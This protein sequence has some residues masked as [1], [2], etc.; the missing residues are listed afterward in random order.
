MI[1]DRIKHSLIRRKANVFLR[2]EFDSFGSHSQVGRA[3][4]AL[5]RAGVLVRLGKGVYAKAKPS[6]LTGNPIPVMP[7]EVLAPEILKK[8]RVDVVPS[9]QSRE[10]N[11]GVS[12]QVPAGVVVDVGTQRVTRILGFNGKFVQYERS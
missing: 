1:F 5:Q 7:L 9:R 3:L 2:S 8:L 11:A 6:V 10:Y 4:I 12:R